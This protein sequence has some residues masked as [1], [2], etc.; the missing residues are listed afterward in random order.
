MCTWVCVYTRPGRE[1]PPPASRLWASLTPV[2]ITSLGKICRGCSNAAGQRSSSQEAEEASSRCKK[3]PAAPPPG[4]CQPCGSRYTAGQR[5]HPPTPGQMGKLRLGD[6]TRFTAEELHRGR[7]ALQCQGTST[8]HTRVLRTCCTHY[9]HAHHTHIACARTRTL[10][11]H[12]VLH[13]QI[14]RTPAPLPTPPGLPHTSL[15]G[16]LM[17]TWS[18]PAAPT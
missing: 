13:I 1:L 16:D 7:W 12:Q 5:T 15:H 17:C 18:P 4:P 6:G 3:K 10:H 11:T 9:T 8:L 14:T 2:S